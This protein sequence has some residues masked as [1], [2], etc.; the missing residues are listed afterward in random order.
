MKKPFLV[1][2]GLE[3]LLASRG[4]ALAYMPYN[5]IWGTQ[6]S[7]TL[8]G[9]SGDDLIYTKHGE[10]AVYAGEGDDRIDTRTLSDAYGDTNG[11][12]L[13]YYGP[14]FDYV[15]V[16]LSDVLADDCEPPT[17]TAAAGV[18]AKPGTTPKGFG[19]YAKTDKATGIYYVLESVGPYLDDYLG[20]TVITY[21]RIREGYDPA[22]MRLDMLDGPT[23]DEQPDPDLLR[24][25]FCPAT[26][27]LEAPESYERYC[28]FT[29]AEEVG[30]SD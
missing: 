3:L 17:L 11:T 19:P 18:L 15:D 14:G 16:D 7:E 30:P 12:D 9:T 27:Q 2:A 6:N 21:G 20:Q 23:S 26:L 1:V 5:S 24:Y 4:V 25:G 13:V 10:D 8:Y 22:V 29:I 28:T